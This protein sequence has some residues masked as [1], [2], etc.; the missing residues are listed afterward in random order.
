MSDKKTFVQRVAS[1]LKMD[2]EGKIGSFQT[3]SLKIINKQIKTRE[4]LLV[5]KKEER[6]EYINEKSPEVVLNINVSRIKTIQ[7]RKEYFEGVYLPTLLRVVEKTSEFDDEVDEIEQEIVAL[8]EVVE[9][10]S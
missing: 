6:D 9:L 8:K 7:D 10:L 4:D 2:D 1:F 5:E 3:Q